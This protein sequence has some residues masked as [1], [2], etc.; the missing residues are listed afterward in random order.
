MMI[1]I[2]GVGDTKLSYLKEGETDFLGRM[3]HYLPV[4]SEWVRSPKTGRKMPPDQI[5]RKEAKILS[6]RIADSA[7]IVALDASGTRVTSETFSKHLSRWMASGVRETVFVIGGP[8]GLDASLLMRSNW[9]LSLSDMT[10][11]HDMTRLILLEQ[12]YRALTLL[13]GEKYHK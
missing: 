4:R 12:I 3:I 11:T 13:R 8:L 5:R 1:R 7:F 2:L 9:I 6:D 10:F